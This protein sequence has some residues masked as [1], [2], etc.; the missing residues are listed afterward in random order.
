MTKLI[1]TIRDI[2]TAIDGRPRVLLYISFLLF[3]V[4]TL[5]RVLTPVLFA[6]IIA[7]GEYTANNIAMGILAYSVLFFL[8]RFVEECRFAVYVCF[9]Q[10]VQKH[11]AL[12]TIETFFHFP[13]SFSRSKSPSENAIVVDRGLSGL[14]VA[15]YNGIF[16]LA[17]VVVEAIIFIAII[18]VRIDWVIASW[19]LAI[20]VSFL[21]ITIRLS[22]KIRALQEKWF[23][24]ATVNYKILSESLRS[25]ETIRSLDRTNWAKTRYR[26]ATDDFIEEVVASLKPG[27]VL[28][29][30]QG[31]LLCV[32]VGSIVGS[33]LFSS[34][35]TPTTVA[36]LVLV[37]GLL[38][39]II[40]PLL[41]F[42]GAYRLFIQGIASSKQLLDLLNTKTIAT[43]IPHT[44]IDDASD[45]VF[46]AE[47]ISISYGSQKIIQN[48]SFTIPSNQLIAI[49]GPSGSG[50]STLARCLAGLYEYDGVI[51]S[52]YNSDKI[53]YLTQD[54]H[55]FDMSI[56]DNIALGLPVIESKILAV[57][58]SC[59]F[60][61]N[62]IS[63]L[64]DRGVGENGANVS[65]GQRQRIGI[66]RLLYHEAQVLILDE[67]T[68]ALDADNANVVIELLKNLSISKT[69]IVVTHDARC[70]NHADIQ[71]KILNGC[72]VQSDEAVPAI[73]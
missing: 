34:G 40:T 17:P 56:Q 47:Q 49:Y 58:E 73:K 2:W 51:K 25:F 68:S 14:R 71:F 66:A 42:S 46:Q 5:C 10:E 16:S 44:V 21:L 57:L 35:I 43:K 41:Q 70:I 26:S 45:K 20:L 9:E 72:V 6:W 22:N 52:L 50:K 15:L 19:A 69:C 61:K 67:P 28:G 27:V 32:L 33:V 64:L 55:L 29:C 38:V 31:L 59:G 53:F 7:S 11:L 8:I 1:F 23:S 4:V 12:K 63:S 48:E 30:L 37:N 18:A 3:G 36:T 13:F 65:G 39:Q 60:T 54:V 62:E 24:T